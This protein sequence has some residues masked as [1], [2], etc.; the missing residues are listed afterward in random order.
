MVVAGKLN[1]KRTEGRQ[2]EERESRRGQERGRARVNL[3][4]GGQGDQGN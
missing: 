2:Y 1:D 4:G 3:G